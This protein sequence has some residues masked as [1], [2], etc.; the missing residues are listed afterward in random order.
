MDLTEFLLAL[1][2]EDEAAAVAA[3]ADDDNTAETLGEDGRWTASYRYVEGRNMTIYDEGGHSEE[4]AQ[5]IARWDPARVL[6]ECEAKRRIVELHSDHLHRQGDC[7]T[8]D[9][10]GRYLVGDCPTIRALAL[11]YADHPDY[12]E[13]WRP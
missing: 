1:I 2:A 7:E 5:H 6:A 4:Q 8:C 12:Q 9:G 10:G 13:G 11:P 3:S